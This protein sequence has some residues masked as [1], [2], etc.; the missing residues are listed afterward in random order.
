MEKMSFERGVEERSS[1][2]CNLSF[3]LIKRYQ[4]MVTAVTKEITNGHL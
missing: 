3:V 2:V 1:N 4:W